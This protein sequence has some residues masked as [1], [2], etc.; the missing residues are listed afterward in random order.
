MIPFRLMTWNLFLDDERDP[1]S[2]GRR[3]EVARSCDAAAALVAARGLPAYA[4]L[5]H[6]L[7][8]D[9]TGADFVRWLGEY[10]LD[11]RVPM[12]GFSWYV[13]S[14]NPVGSQNI[15]GYLRGLANVVTANGWNSHESAPSP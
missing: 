12:D 15:H 11:N 2:D 5:D 3:W 10:V 7:G 13:H 4:S 9:K 8:A 14:Q 6:D 1:P